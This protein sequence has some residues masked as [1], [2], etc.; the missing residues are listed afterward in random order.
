MLLCPE[1]PLLSWSFMPLS[2]FVCS[3]IHT[4]IQEFVQKAFKDSRKIPERP[5]AGGEQEMMSCLKKRVKINVSL[6]SV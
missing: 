6:F 1:D 4:R 5:E 2:P 3:K